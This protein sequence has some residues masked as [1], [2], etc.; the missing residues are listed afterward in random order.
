MGRQEWPTPCSN[1]TTHLYNAPLPSGHSLDMYTL[2]HN[3]STISHFVR[4]GP[5]K[6]YI[7]LFSW[8]FDPHPPSRNANNVEPYSFVTLF[9]WKADTPH[10]L[11][12]YITLEWPRANS[13][14]ARAVFQVGSKTTEKA[15][16]AWLSLVRQTKW[17][18]GS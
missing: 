11:L 4:K 3:E 15:S 7:M 18:K 5:F 9:S 17:C 6:C 10:P 2:Q 8:K 13:F 12:R 16:S 1:Q 14:P